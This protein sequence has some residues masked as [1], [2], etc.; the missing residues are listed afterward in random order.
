MAERTLAMIKP[1]G[2]RWAA[3]IRRAIHEAGFRVVAIRELHF[4]PAQVVGFY[5]EEHRGRPY[6]EDLVR[7]MSSGRICAMVL[8]LAAP[9]SDGSDAVQ[10]WRKL[11]GPTDASQAPKDTIRGHYWSGSPNKSENVAH[12]SDSPAAAEREIAFFFAGI[13]LIDND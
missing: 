9:T 5:G 2:M 4:W 12:G 6:F 13:D 10:A 7:H 1:D 8:E 3:Q 11:L